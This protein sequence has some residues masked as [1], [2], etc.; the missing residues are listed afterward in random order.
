[1]NYILKSDLN[2]VID[3]KITIGTVIAIYIIVILITNKKLN[4][5]KLGGIN[6]WHVLLYLEIYI[7][8]RDL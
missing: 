4:N 5:S 8:E 2:T 7:M 3:K 1:M 6:L